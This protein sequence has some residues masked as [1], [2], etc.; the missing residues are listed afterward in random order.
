[1]PPI[2]IARPNANK[3]RADFRA[4]ILRIPKHMDYRLTEA[5]GELET[6]K[7]RLI[8]DNLISTIDW[9]KFF[10]ANELAISVFRAKHGITDKNDALRAILEDWL[11]ANAPPQGNASASPASDTSGRSE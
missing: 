7:Y 2:K 6:A 1:M 10:Q 3:G 5:A 8:V 4:V 11:R 9:A